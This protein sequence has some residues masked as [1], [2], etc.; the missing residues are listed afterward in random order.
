M[1]YNILN[2]LKRN[3]HQ[4][5]LRKLAMKHKKIDKK[6]KPTDIVTE[7]IDPSSELY[8]PQIRFGYH[9]KH[10]HFIEDKTKFETK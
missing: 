6:Y 1:K 8:G 9:P 10:T 5:S 3:S 4:R 2:I 7:Y